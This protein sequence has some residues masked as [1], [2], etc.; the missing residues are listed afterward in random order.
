MP[1]PTI[2][3]HLHFGVTPCPMSEK[4][5][6]P[7]DWPPDHRWSSYWHDVNCQPCRELA[8]CCKPP[9]TKKGRK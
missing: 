8:T 4:Y 6:L 2:I 3:H 5:G 9:T 7:K 1:D